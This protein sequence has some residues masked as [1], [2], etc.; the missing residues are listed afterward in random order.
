[1]NEFI[2]PKKNDNTSLR[3][4]RVEKVSPTP[5]AVPRKSKDFTYDEIVDWQFWAGDDLFYPDHFYI[6]ID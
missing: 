3:S 5:A 4:C 2:S 6:F 1:M